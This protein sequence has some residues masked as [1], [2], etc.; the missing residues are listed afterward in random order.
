MTSG[1]SIRA[2][3]HEA[4]SDPLNPRIAVLIPCRN[5]G[6]TVGTVVTD[7]ARA[8]P[9]AT[10]YVYD[11]DSIDETAAEARA[12]GAIVQHEPHLGKGNVV[13]RMFADID[14]DV[15]V[16]VDG[17]ATYEAS[18][19]P[20]MVTQLVT[21]ELDMVSGIRV[22]TGAAFRKGHRFG[23]RILSALVRAMFGTGIDDMLSGYKVLS[24]R[25]VKSLPLLSAGF[26][27]E[28]EI[29]V[30]AL[31]MRLRVAEMPTAYVERPAGSTSKLRT[32]RDGGRI[33]RIIVMLLKDE[34]P[35]WFFGTVAGLLALL[36]LALAVPII[37]TFAETGLVPRLPTAVLS[38]SI[39]LLAFLALT[40]GLILDTVSRG[41]REQKLIAYLACGR[42]HKA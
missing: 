9:L 21:Q 40:C 13:R 7:F 14:A 27:V 20:T 36:S 22:G 6:S 37:A 19:A 16:L 23:N 34:R 18:A 4:V 3:D 1:S 8:L 31:S 35:L 5:E 42:D 32:W 15:Y 30:H 10:V 39:M 38:A 26:E 29:V 28:T 41:R 11:N 24:R 25:F 2:P 12:A 17:D 33:L